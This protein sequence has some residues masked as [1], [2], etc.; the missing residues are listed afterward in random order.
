MR[1]EDFD[2]AYNEEP[3]DPEPV[4]FTDRFRA[5]KRSDM[6]QAGARDPQPPT[7]AV[8][9]ARPQAA[10]RPA[11]PRPEPQQRSEPYSP[12][13]AYSHPSDPLPRRTSQPGDDLA[14]VARPSGPIQR[15]SA[16]L[17][18]PP[19]PPQQP[20]PQ[21]NYQPPR[22]APGEQYA[23]NQQYRQ[24]RPM[25]RPG[26]PVQRPS[27][28]VRRPSQ[29]MPRPSGQINRPSQ[30]VPRPQHPAQ[31]PQEPQRQFVPDAPRAGGR[32]AAPEPDGMH[33][34]A[35]SSQADRVS[36]ARRHRLDE[37]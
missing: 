22:P 21:Q 30:P 9:T 6:E 7:Q 36:R 26:G 5:I 11:P 23:P 25:Q 4:Y 2:R 14:G 28:P 3:G 17:Q 18:R 32:H 13:Q 31:A 35:S 12:Q 34:P 1:R 20:A 29:P 33:H 8:P 19:V 16:D 15:E 27:G 10:Q 37:D 24:S